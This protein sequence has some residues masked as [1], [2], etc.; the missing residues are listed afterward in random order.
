MA[1]MQLPMHSGEMT[2][3]SS[4][5]PQHIYWLHMLR[6][7]DKSPSRLPLQGG[8]HSAP[9]SIEG[10]GVKTW[11]VNWRSYPRPEALPRLMCAAVRAVVCPAVCCSGWKMQM[12]FPRLKDSTT[13]T[14]CFSGRTKPA[15]GGFM[16][17]RERERDSLRPFS[18][19]G[20]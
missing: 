18:Q 9:S 7:A 14:E 2:S 1:S 11:A 20:L 6:T 17:E 10:L 8:M 19:P 15:S 16:R 13:Q 4:A 12:A 5:G 3:C